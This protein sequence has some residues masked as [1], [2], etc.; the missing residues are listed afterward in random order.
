MRLAVLIELAAI[1]APAD[2]RIP[3]PAL[4]AGQGRE[5]RLAAEP[6]GLGRVKAFGR[7]APGARGKLPATLDEALTELG[8]LLNPRQT[9]IVR[10][11]DSIEWHDTL[12]RALRNCWGL[13]G[14]GPLG[15]WFDRQGVRHPDDISAIVLE[16]FRRRLNGQPIDLPGQIK[17][18]QDYWKRA[19]AD[20]QNGT[21]SGGTYADIVRFRE[22]EGWVSL[23]GDR[24]PHM[25]DL[26][27]PIRD[28][29][30]K[31]I[32]A[33]W[34][35]FPRTEGG[36]AKDTVIKLAV[37]SDG[38]VATAEITKTP[39]PEAHAKCLAGALIGVLAPAHAGATYSL[40]FGIYRE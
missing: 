15:D 11:S 23:H 12:G 38:R 8:R 13:W 16:S 37:G 3:A 19:E 28:Q 40:D 2:P 31:A 7:C 18:Y 20:Y 6:R 5:S 34:A 39:L 17:T 29:A 24:V 26:Y 30:G 4:I 32:E 9:A 27:D 36:M 22:H 10:S 21:A 33:C 1:V 25:F 14:D 35:K